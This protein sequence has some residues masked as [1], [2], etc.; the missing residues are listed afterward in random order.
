MRINI[1]AIRSNA[2]GAAIE[3]FQLFPLEL[4]AWG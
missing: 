3:R 1:E 4:A 2:D